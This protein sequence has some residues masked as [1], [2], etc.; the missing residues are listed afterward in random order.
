MG[1][2]LVVLLMPALGPTVEAESRARTREAL[3]QVGFAL[4]A[5]R[6]DHGT[7][8]DSL[9]ALTPKYISRMPNDLYTEQPL[10]YRRQGAGFLLYSVGENGVDD[11][12][13]TFD[14]QPRGDDIV[15]RVSGEQPKKQ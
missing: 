12:G 2:V 4:A 14:S 13:R 15:L 3:E 9:S 6:A 8:P 5:H 10:N 7:Y 1:R 11:G